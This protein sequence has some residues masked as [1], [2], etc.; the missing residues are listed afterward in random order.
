MARDAHVLDADVARS[1]AGL[2][3]DLAPL[4]GST[5]TVT[6]GT[7]F[8]GSWI[9]E[10]VLHLNDVH[11]FGTELVLLA[12]DTERFAAT[13]PHLAGRSG[14]GLISADVRHLTDLPKATTWLLHAAGNP[15]NRAHSSMPLETMRIIAEGT[16]NVLETA[17]RCS[18]L[19]LF[20]H[21][22]SGLVY[23]P[24]PADIDTIG[25]HATGSAPVLTASSAYAEAKRYA[26]S[27]LR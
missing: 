6:G 15:D 24:Q 8:I 5:V 4:R 22:S 16:A 11:A 2:L 13:R 3:D 21:L 9:A 14:I 7:G 17:A 25:E 19:R 1:V 26:E 23:G 20:L 27:T 10:T 18:A 12:R